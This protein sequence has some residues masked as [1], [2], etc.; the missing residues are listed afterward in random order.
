M[1]LPSTQKVAVT[2]SNYKKIYIYGAPFSGKTTFADTAPTPLNLNTD[3]NVKYVTMPRLAIKDEVITSGR[4]TKRKFAWEVFTEAID[5]LEKGSEFK[6]VVVD[7]LEDIYDY[8]RVYECDKNGWQHESDDSF[9]AYDI[10]RSEF[11]RNIKRLLNL[12]YNII[13]ISHE[14]TSRDI[15]SRDKKITAI[16]PNLAEKIRNKIAGMVDI[17]ARVVIEDDGSRSLNFKSNEV[18]FGGGRLQGIKTTKCGL[19][20]DDLCKVYDEAIYKKVRTEPTEHEL[21]V[22]EFKKAHSEIKEEVLPWEVEKENKTEV[23]VA[24][25]VKAEPE[26][27]TVSAAT[28]TRRVRRVRGE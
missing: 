20:W 15:M 28:P 26:Q 16:A 2:A 4:I 3:G 25:E 1:S 10:V 5:E 23:P 6:T 8:C 13:L 21:K 24:E 22:E 19:T 11:L 17:V 9:K 18:T 27:A 14:D 12:P 7:L